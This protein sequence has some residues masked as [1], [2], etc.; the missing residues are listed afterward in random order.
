MACVFCLLTLE[1]R[2]E[3]QMFSI[4]LLPKMTCGYY[5]TILVLLKNLPKCVYLQNFDL[6]YFI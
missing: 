2:I 6:S 3:L 5:R 4:E 1:N